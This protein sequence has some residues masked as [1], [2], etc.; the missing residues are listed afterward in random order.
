MIRGTF[1]N[2]RIKNKMVSKN[3]PYTVVKKDEDP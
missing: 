3:G 2:I 1:G